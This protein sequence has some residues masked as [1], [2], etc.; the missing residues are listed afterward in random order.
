MMIRAAKIALLLGLLADYA[1]VVF[2][3]LT[4]FNSNYQFVRHVLAMDT[5]F[6]GNHGMVRAITAPWVQLLFYVLIIAWE[7]VTTILLAWG[8]ARLFRARRAPSAEFDRAKNIAVLALTVSLLLWLGAF[9]TVGG[10]WFLMW[11]SRQWNGQQEA[12]R[13]FVVAGIVLLFLTRPERET[14]P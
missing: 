11:Q 5:T 12:F 14:Q 9:L 8:A 1:L 7:I 6:P 4:D 2:D 10:E 13:M 3:N